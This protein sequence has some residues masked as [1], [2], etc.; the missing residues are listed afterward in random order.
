[1]HFVLES[2]IDSTHTVKE[3]SDVIHIICKLLPKINKKVYVHFHDI[4]LPF[5]FPEDWVVGESRYWEEQYLIYAFLLGNKNT[6]VLYGSALCAHYFPELMTNFTYSKFP[7]G[8][9]IWFELN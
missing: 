3:G 5:C 4:F 7:G 1:L 8:G 2:A 9:S 6:K